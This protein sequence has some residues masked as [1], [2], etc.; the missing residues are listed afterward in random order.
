MSGF[1]TLNT[2]GTL[3]YSLYDIGH[4]FHVI[5]SGGAQGQA[6]TQPCTNSSKARA[7][8]Q[9]TLTLPK[10]ITANLIVHE[11]GHQFG[12]GHTY[13]AVGGSTGSPTFFSFVWS[14]VSAVEPGAGTTIMSY[15]N[16]CTTPNNQTN[17]GNNGLNYFNAK[18]LRHK[19]SMVFFVL[20]NVANRE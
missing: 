17:T 15:G 20:N 10:S 14:S 2:N 3:A 1:N 19:C 6:G 9:W 8:S 11:M 13:N 4:T 12:A 7:W 18:S 16:N 5:T